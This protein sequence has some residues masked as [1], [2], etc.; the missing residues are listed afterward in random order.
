[1]S[2]ESNPTVQISSHENITLYEGL[3]SLEHSLRTI[4]ET[5]L[6]SS[7][8][9]IQKEE[10]LQ[11]ANSL[12]SIQLFHLAASFTR[13]GEG[14][15]FLFDIDGVFNKNSVRNIFACSLDNQAVEVLTSFCQIFEA[16]NFIALTSRPE[17]WPLPFPSILQRFLG[18]PRQDWK[19]VVLRAIGGNISMP[20]SPGYE[21]RI[22][23]LFQ[24]GTK[25]RALLTD[26]G[27][28]I[29]E[30]LILPFL[31]RKNGL[32]GMNINNYPFILETIVK[33]YQGVLTFID[34]GSYSK[35]YFEGLANKFPQIPLRYFSITEQVLWEDIVLFT[36]QVLRLVIR[37]RIQSTLLSFTGV[38]I[39][40]IKQ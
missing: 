40:T 37:E 2:K 29:P 18:T 14:Y 38:L 30:R 17:S 8:P 33:N 9:P 22:Q 11:F 21:G 39:P 1:M 19:N 20:T 23:A 10:I 7:C 6:I 5:I 36:D 3:V 25:I 35:L 24:E 16:A 28:N 31:G 13:N 32:R 4:C 15:T 27:K 34:S 26:T 12:N